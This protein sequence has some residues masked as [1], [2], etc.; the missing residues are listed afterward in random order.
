MASLGGF[1]VAKEK[2][3]SLLVA[4]TYDLV[5]TKCDLKTFGD[6]QKIM[7]EF[8]V[9]NGEFQN[10]KLEQSY[11]FAWV[12][13]TTPADGPQT[14]IRIGRAG[15]GKICK[16]VGILAPNDTNDLVG[17]S[18]TAAVKIKEG[19]GGYDDENT[20][21]KASPRTTGGPVAAPAGV[22]GGKW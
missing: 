21:A 9:L 2:A 20:I 1:D 13:N 6:Y 15:F 19:K 11:A 14:A 7:L 3:G 4:G 12:G 8:S 16:A 18:F 5:I 10:R 17:K 22:G